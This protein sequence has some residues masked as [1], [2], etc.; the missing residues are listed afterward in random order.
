MKKDYQINCYCFSPSCKNSIFN[1]H[2]CVITKRS[3]AEAAAVEAKCECCGQELVS[4]PILRMTRILNGALHSE[5]TL[6]SFVIDDDLFFHTTAKDLFNHSER[7]KKSRHLT[8]AQEALDYLSRHI[9]NPELIPDYIFLDV[10]M[11]LMNA[12]DFL[13][14]FDGIFPRLSKKISIYIITNSILP[15][16][17]ARIKHFANVKAIIEKNFDLDFLNTIH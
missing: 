12:W 16:Y 1:A 8:C 9:D 2:T 13:E 4:A 7:F 11:P 14:E 3:F 17:Q 10:N 6:T 15:A 5:K